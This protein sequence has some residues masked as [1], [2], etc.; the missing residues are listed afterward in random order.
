[1]CWGAFPELR[2]EISLQATKRPQAGAASSGPE[3][4]CVLS[5]PMARTSLLASLGFLAPLRL[6]EE[7][8][9]LHSVHSCCRLLDSSASLASIPGS[10]WP[11]SSSTNLSLLNLS[12]GRKC[13]C[14]S[15]EVGREQWHG[16]RI[17]NA[18]IQGRGLKAANV[19]LFSPHL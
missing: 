7:C 9:P 2:W 8:A 15:S 10:K 17:Y 5:S 13:M 4:K 11:F 19:T 3:V 14:T 18:L 1:M 6:Q 16:P 12:A